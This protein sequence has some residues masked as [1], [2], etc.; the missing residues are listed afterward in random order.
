MATTN[1]LFSLMKFIGNT[2][3]AYGP[4]QKYD[5][6]NY[7]IERNNKATLQES[8]NFTSWQFYNI[9]SNEIYN[10]GFSTTDVLNA[11]ENTIA[12][13]GYLLTKDNGEFT[14]NSSFIIPIFNSYNTSDDPTLYYHLIKET[15]TVSYFMQ[16]PYA[17]SARGEK[18]N[19][20]N[21][22]Y[23]S[24]SA[25][26]FPYPTSTNMNSV[27]FIKINKNNNDNYMPISLGFR[28]YFEITHSIENF[29]VRSYYVN[30]KEY[31]LSFDP[32][33]KLLTTSDQYGNLSSNFKDAY[34]NALLH[35]YDDK[36]IILDYSGQGT[37]YDSTMS[38]AGVITYTDVDGIGFFLGAY[39][40]EGK[41][42]IVYTDQAT[43]NDIIIATQDVDDTWLHVTNTEANNYFNTGSLVVGDDKF[44]LRNG[45]RYFY[46]TKIDNF[47]NFTEITEDLTKLLYVN[48]LYIG[49]Y[50]N[51]IKYSTD[52]I[53]FSSY[54]GETDPSYRIIEM[55]SSNDIIY[56]LS[57][58]SSSDNY[59]IYKSVDG[60]SLE[61]ILDTLIQNVPHAQSS[62]LQFS[63][64]KD[65]ILF[66]NGRYNGTTWDDFNVREKA[67]RSTNTQ[68]VDN[69][70]IISLS[71]IIQNNIN[72]KF[73]T[74]DLELESN[75]VLE[76]DAPEFQLYDI[77]D[78]QNNVINMYFNDIINDGE[79][80][81]WLLMYTTGEVE[82]PPAFGDL[83]I[84]I[85]TKNNISNDEES[86]TYVT[87][88]NESDLF[89]NRFLDMLA[90]TEQATH[91]SFHYNGK[92][93]FLLLN[94]II[95]A[96]YDLVDWFDIELYST[97]DFTTTTPIRVSNIVYAQSLFTDY[98]L[99]INS[100]NDFYVTPMNYSTATK[101]VSNPSY[102][103]T[104]N[105]AF[106]TA[107]ITPSLPLDVQVAYVEDAYYDIHNGNGTLHIILS[108]ITETDRTLS[109]NSLNGSQLVE[110]GTQT[111][112][113]DRSVNIESI[114]N[115]YFVSLDFSEI[116]ILDTLTGDA[117]AIAISG[118]EFNPT[119]AYVQTSSH[120]PILNTLD[121]IIYDHTAGMYY[122]MT[123]NIDEETVTNG[124]AI[125]EVQ[126]YDY[127]EKIYNST[128]GALNI[129]YNIYDNINDITTYYLRKTINGT[130][131]TET[132]I[133]D[134]NIIDYEEIFYNQYID[135]FIITKIE[136][137]SITLYSSSDCLTWE[138]LYEMIIDIDLNQF[139]PQI[140]DNGN[141]FY[142]AEEQGL[143]F[144]S[145]ISGGR[146]QYILIRGIAS[147][148]YETLD[149]NSNRLYKISKYTHSNNCV[150]FVELNDLV[151]GGTLPADAVLFSTLKAPEGYH[152]PDNVLVSAAVTNKYI[153]T[154]II[155]ISDH[156]PSV[157]SYSELVN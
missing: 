72:R 20:N 108:Q 64:T 65:G 58:D 98:F 57:K 9:L 26:D 2:A 7:G 99:Q 59:K 130:D 142:L 90:V 111:I 39:Q 135:K 134:S 128:E 23:G 113:I 21:S 13:N 40:N 89:N 48:N 100:D 82:A 96:S 91:R 27:S 87:V 69:G 92:I 71:N 155:G 141:T 102:L 124:E 42:N 74:I 70:I 5:D 37:L 104:G 126:E 63:A 106:E 78:A 97:D 4:V 95:V 123:I 153:S 28:P 148:T 76:H 55:L 81:I 30:E 14:Y 117:K 66:F 118:I 3:Y 12:D 154:T 115:N 122:P 38:E 139:P 17:L 31:T 131:W 137:N 15:E 29:T 79:K 103:F 18:L 10:D 51:T 62:P 50:E 86:W 67:F 33:D 49:Y 105:G 19:A 77:V 116:R 61:L 132:E 120:N 36:F 138:L 56:I 110:I 84:E 25:G 101:F 35:E 46:C 146:G 140:T 145:E 1:Y 68:L 60:S 73:Y 121:F 75:A 150:T 149:N 85:R 93:Y 34:Q 127:Y 45:T 109:I 119:T 144:Y 107:N 22:I 83:H 151:T 114:F 94:N 152:K 43:E 6:G 88:N 129:I 125:A 8:A 53:S 52:G 32:N 54:E 16:S 41:L 47:N 136:N 143:Q 157:I 80:Y 156:K 24:G 44:Y 11:G 112:P 147:A 133:T